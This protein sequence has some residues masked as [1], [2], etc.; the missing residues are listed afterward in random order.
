[1]NSAIKKE[2]RNMGHEKE[3]VALL[4]EDS[5]FVFEEDKKAIQYLARENRYIRSLFKRAS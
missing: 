1:M 3:K 5:P 4:S 2:E